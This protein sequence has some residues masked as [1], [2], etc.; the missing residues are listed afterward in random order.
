MTK[1]LACAAAAVALACGAPAVASAEPAV[2]GPPSSMAALGDSITRA[3]NTGPLPFADWPERSWSTGT[4]AAV[5]S[6]YGRLLGLQPSIA[7]NAYNDAQT[8]ADSADLNAQAQQAV[9]QGVEYV[10]ILMGANDVCAS[11]E[12]AM[13]P[14]ATFRARV[15]AALATLAAGVPNTRVYVVSVPDVY[16]LWSLLKGNLLARTVWSIASICQS[17]LANAAST[18][19]ADEARRLRVRQRNIDLNAQL[20]AACAAQ[21]HCRYDGGAAFNTVF[22]TA[23][24]SNRDYFHP[25]AS[26]QGTAA[27][28]TW[29]AG[30]D[31]TDIVAP[32]SRAWVA[33]IATGS[34][35]RLTATDAAG[36]AGIEYRIGAASWQRST[37]ALTVPAGAALTWRAVDRNGNAEATHRLVGRLRR[38]MSPVG[39]T[40]R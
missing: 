16:H 30:Y 12:A 24:V 35:V 14:V 28:V 18:D 39:R 13:T 23:D 7:G 37:G 17:L 25:S 40:S 31:F 26:G 27:A 11:S 4:D 29:A 5:G 33:P 22:A 21:V 20:Q 38:A 34:R 19:P 9:G 32:R 8:G 2:V 3:F 15:A 6:H 1:G 36:I 10:T